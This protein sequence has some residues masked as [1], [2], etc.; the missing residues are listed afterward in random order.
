MPAGQIRVDP[1]DGLV[2]A[3]DEE[4]QLTW[5]DARRDGVSFTPRAGKAVEINALWHH[6]LRVTAEL[7]AESDSALGDELLRQAERVGDSFRRRFWN[8]AAG[9]LFDLVPEDGA[10][11]DE[12]AAQ[13]RPNQVFAVS[14]RHSALSGEQQRAVVDV[15]GRRLL[16]PFGLRTL[17]PA[18]AAYRA[19][20]AGPLRSRDEAYHNGTAWPWLLGVYVEAL[21]RSEGFSPESRREGRRVLQPLIDEMEGACPGQIAEVYDGGRADFSSATA[22]GKA[23]A[24][25]RDQHP[26]GCPAQAWSVAMT[27][28]ALRLTLAGE[29]VTPAGGA[30]AGP[31]AAGR[32]DPSRRTAWPR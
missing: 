9:C 14:L 2:V 6:G 30:Q 7:V 13:I 3:G 29:G 19:E 25:A 32:R 18:D 17:D 11:R 10:R 31:P 23:H 5:M 1:T 8:P 15:V 16:T 28:R 21:L 22:T 24:P 20:Y 27:L 12:A 4:T 26:D